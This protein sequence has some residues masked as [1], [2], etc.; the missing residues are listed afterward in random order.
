MQRVPASM[1]T[2]EELT[3][4]IEGRLS[5]A[6]AKDA[7]VKLATRLVVEEALEAEAGDTIGREYYEPFHSVIRE[8][9]KGHTQALE[10]LAI[11][12][13]ARGALGPRHR[14]CLQGRERAVAAV[15]NCGATLA[16]R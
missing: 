1:R 6:S 15:T 7:L 2:R 10:G 9:L 5:T 11:A 8:H 14:R 16:Q 12:M 4:L 13:L 3:S